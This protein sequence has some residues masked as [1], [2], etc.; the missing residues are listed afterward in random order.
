[1]SANLTIRDIQ[2]HNYDALDFLQQDLP[3]FGF[4]LR[5]DAHVGR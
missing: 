4:R 1:M 3:V 5:L 2:P